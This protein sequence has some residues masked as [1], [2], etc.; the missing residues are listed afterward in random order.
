MLKSLKKLWANRLGALIVMLCAYLLVFGFG[1]SYRESPAAIE[2]AADPR[3]PTIVIDAGHG[4]I[5]S[6]CVSINGAEEKDIN[7]NILLNLRQLLDLAGFDTVVTRDSD[8]S[9]HDLGVTGLGNQKKSDM[10]NRLA[11]INSCEDAI[12]ISIH[13]NQFTD[14]Q[15]YGAQMFYPAESQ[16][17]QRLAQI[18]QN[19]IVSR[20]QPENKREIKPVGDEIYLLHY[21]KFP[22]VM[23]ECGFLSNQAEADLLESEEYQ[24]KVA[25]SIFAG[26]CE[27]LFSQTV[28]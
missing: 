2:T 10:E 8:R 15:Y 24:S 5:D 3:F 14:P 22:A 12:F 7:L 9:I 19:S 27:Y 18:L 20:L 16:E 23:A 17:S 13:Q 26:I 25:F 1:N 6:G 21:S 28:A 4:G 11:I